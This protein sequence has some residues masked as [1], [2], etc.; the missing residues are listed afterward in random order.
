MIVEGFV[1][2]AP[3]FIEGDLVDFEFFMGFFHVGSSV[4][5]GSTGEKGNELLLALSLFFHVGVGEEWRSDL[6][7][8]H[9]NVELVNN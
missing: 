4:I 9:V 8:Q 1:E 2:I 5:V 7:S 6:V 3:G